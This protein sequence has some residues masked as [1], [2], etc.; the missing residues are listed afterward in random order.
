MAPNLVIRT[1]CMELQGI[2]QIG[3]KIGFFTRAGRCR[4]RPV[5]FSM[6]PLGPQVV[7]NLA[8]QWAVRNFGNRRILNGDMDEKP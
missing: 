8:I 5:R 3:I 4:C 2:P 6:P 7:S 1:I